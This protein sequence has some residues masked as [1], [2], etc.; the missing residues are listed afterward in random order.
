MLALALTAPWWLGAAGS[1]PVAF[2]CAVAF[3][4]LLQVTA[5]LLNALP[6]PGLDGYG[7]LEPWLSPEVRRQAAPF[8]PF[9]M[10]I[11]FG[12]LWIPEVNAV[13][14]DAMDAVMRTLGVSPAETFLGQRYFRFW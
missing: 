10:L 1:M 6:V 12:F 11:V 13:F 4:A 2:R 5:A 14:W 8:A 9:G 3:L 7:V